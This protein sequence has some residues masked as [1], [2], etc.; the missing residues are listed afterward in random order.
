MNKTSISLYM[1]DQKKSNLLYSADS[2]LDVDS[3][4]PN[5]FNRINM[6]IRRLIEVTQLFI[7]TLTIKECVAY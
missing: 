2:L 5:K 6:M 7:H 4:D 1:D 3:N